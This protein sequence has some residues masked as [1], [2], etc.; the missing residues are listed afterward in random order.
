MNR[1]QF[2]QNAALAAGSLWAG[3]LP[4]APPKIS[5]ADRMPLGRTGIEV[6]RLCI[7]TG[8]RGFGG[9]SD[10]TALGIEGLADLLWYAF[11]QGV[12]FW[13]TADAYGSHP[14]VAQA[15][16][17][18]RRDRVVINTKS[19]TRTADGI[20]ADIERYRREL[21]TDYLDTVL[22]HCL[23]DPEWPSKMQGAVDVL[24][25]ARQK[26]V[27]RAHGV[28]CHSIGALRA[29]ART[30]WVQVSLARL[31][32]AGV[33]MDVAP[34]VVL[35]VLKEMKAQ[36]KGVFVMKVIGQGKLRDRID[37]SLAFALNSGVP[38][39]LN[40]GFTSRVQID[41]IARRIPVAQA[42]MLER[43]AHHAA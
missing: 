30:P 42:V 6:S 40:I 1:R 28:S 18:V 22:L 20:R 10:Q 38:D 27:L 41:H 33:A 19:W 24:S 16:K 37:E 21:N 13:D 9:R 3:G 43:H 26:G 35:P 25:E 7:G 12:T 23:T 36:G 32:P 29:A 11:D 39:A 2:L 5:H 8:T 31:N 15:L 17:R 4:A 14:H 34:D